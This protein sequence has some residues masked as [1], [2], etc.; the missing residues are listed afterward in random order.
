MVALD[1]A[2]GRE[3][4]PRVRLPLLLCALAILPLGCTAQ[5]VTGE[6]KGEPVCPDFAVGKT[7]TKMKGSL[8][9]PVQVSILEDEEPRWQR[10][11]LGKRNAE[12]P[13]S[14]FV[15]PDSDETYNLRFAQ[16][17]NQFAPRPVDDKRPS[18][19]GGNYRCGETEVYHE[20][21]LEI[22]EG[23]ASSRVFEW[24]VPPEPS[25]WTTQTPDAK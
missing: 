20:V 10:V 25:C 21:P 8:K 9:Q 16:C 18:D 13:N 14:K 15:V 11:I 4:A 2:G 7:V 24:V 6:I 1:E 22:R 19:D 3:Q 5:S 17:S 12:D 23:D